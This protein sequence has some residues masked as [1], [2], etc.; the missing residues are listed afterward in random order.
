MDLILWRHADA[1]DDEADMARELTA[2]GR[3]QAEK[4]ADWLRARI[5]DSTRILVSPAVRALQTA[6][7]LGLEYEVIAGIAPGAMGVQVLSEAGWPDTTGTVLLVGHQ[8][9]LGDAASLLLFGETR[10]LSIKKG[11]LIWLTNRVRGSQPQTVIKAAITP[12]LA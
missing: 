1:Q 3:K 4:V 12:E 6:D 11:G 7:A 9:T 8:P 10:T 5:P 2:K